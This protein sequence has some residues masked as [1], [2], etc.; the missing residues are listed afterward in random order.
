MAEPIFSIIVPVY[1][2]AANL[3]VSLPVYLEFARNLAGYR[4]E[5]ICVDDGSTDGSLQVLVD[6]QR[7][8]P[9]VM[10]VVK[11][12]RNFGQYNALMA[13]IA[14]AEGD[15]MGQLTADMQ[16][17]VELFAEMLAKW[18]EGYKIVIGE[19]TKRE[20]HRM[21]AWFSR[22]FNRM[23]NR[24][25][26][27]RFPKEGFDFFILDREV[28]E[29]ALAINEKNT[30]LQV[31]M[32]WLG[33]EYT[34]VP[35]VRKRREIG[36]SSWTFWRKVKR[37][38]DVF[39]TNSY[40]PI[41]FVSG[42]GLTAALG[43]VAYA[44][45]RIIR[46]LAT[47]YSGEVRGWTSTAVLITFFSGAILFSLGIIGEYLW[48]IFDNTKHRPLFVIERADPPPADDEGG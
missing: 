15:V 43:A 37:V 45:Y 5:V 10:R 34:T 12:T 38:I 40:K 9:D 47:G 3:P 24:M 23:V 42:L 33:Y 6:F 35:Y 2:N 39:V 7:R 41:R 28:A 8:N 30:S 21:R 44:A 13:G 22:S 36:R 4:V 19:R 20:D 32:L 16:D 46:W 29:R 11:L 17:P 14:V 26:D 27:P 1:Q 31:V 25:I 18:R 48:R